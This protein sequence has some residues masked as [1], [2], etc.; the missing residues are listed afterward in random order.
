MHFKFDFSAP[1]AV[2]IFQDQTFD[3]NQNWLQIKMWQGRPAQ[4]FQGKAGK[5]V[6]REGG[7]EV[8]GIAQA[9]ADTSLPTE[10]LSAVILMPL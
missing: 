2:I 9:C 4:A 1:S 5:A 7:G 3:R 8:S 10:V 6:E